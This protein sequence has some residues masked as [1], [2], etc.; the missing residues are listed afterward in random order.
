VKI[1]ASYASDGRV[2]QDS[3]SWGE[4]ALSGL[5]GGGFVFAGETFGYLTGKI[6]ELSV[7]DPLRTE[8]PS[9]YESGTDV[10][11]RVAQQH[12]SSGPDALMEYMSPR[13]QA[14][15]LADPSNG[16]RFLGQAVHNATADSLQQQYGS[17]FLYSRVGPDFLDRDTGEIIELTTPQAVPAHMAKPGYTSVNYATYTW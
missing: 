12:A 15:Y 9:A 17:R 10:V 7:S 13:E 3:F 4:L 5:A 14:A 6:S 16:S 11:Q 2:G 1:G 8:T